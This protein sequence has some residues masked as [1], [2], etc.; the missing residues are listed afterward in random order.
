MIWIIV[1]IIGIVILLAVAATSD[2]TPTQEI[3]YEPPRRHSKPPVHWDPNHFI[4]MRQHRNDERH[5]RHKRNQT[6]W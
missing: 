6:P 1:A 5:A 2:T 4:H 3:D